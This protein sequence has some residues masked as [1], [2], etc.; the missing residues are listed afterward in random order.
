VIDCE[1]VKEEAWER[2]EKFR[3]EISIEETNHEE[4]GKG[5][6]KEEQKNVIIKIWYDQSE[7]EYRRRLEKARF[8]EQE[9]KKMVK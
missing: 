4:M 1:I 5:G 7:E 2:V 9:V 6:A 3:I 8:E